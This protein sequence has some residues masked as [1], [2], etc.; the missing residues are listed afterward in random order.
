MMQVQSPFLWG[1]KG[2][3]LTPEQV[4]R[5]REQA[6][7][8]MKGVGD[9]SPVGHWLQGAGRV[10]NAITGKVKERRADASEA[11]GMAG[12][13]EYVRNNPVLSGLMGG[14]Q[15]QPA[16]FNGTM[17]A[18]GSGGLPASLVSSESGGNWGALNSEGYGG[19][20]QFGA[21]RL[22][23][24]ARAGIIPAGMTGAEYSKAP[25]EVQLAVENWHKNNILGDLGKYVGM[26]IDGAG[27][28]PPMTEDSILAVAHLGGTGGARQ[29]IESGGAYNPSDSNGTSL[30]D[31]A[32]SHSGGGGMSASG[33][34]MPIT[35]GGADVV[36]ALASAMS[37]PWVAK[38]Y[39]PVIEALMG[40]QMQ[41]GD[42]QY[43][44]QLAQS[45][46]AYQL[47]LQKS[48]LELDAMRNPAAPKP[49]EV[50]GVLL[51]PTTYQPIFDSRTPDAPEPFTLAPGQ[52][53]FDGAGNPI[54]SVAQPAEPGFT[55]VTPEEATA[56][57][58]PPGAYQKGPDGKIYAIGGGG[59]TVNNDMSGGKFE[60]AFAKGDAATLGLISESGIAATRNLS[61]IDQ[62]ESLLG[63][64]PTG[65]SGAMKQAAG[66][67]GINT[68]GLNEIQAAQALVNS[69]V[70]EQRQP[71]SGP[72]SDAD[73][74]LFKQS[75]PRII[76]QP[77]GNKIIL[78]TMRAIAQ[79]DAQGAAIVQQLRAGDL[80][81]AQAFSMLMARPNPMQGFKP[82][83]QDGGAAE[84]PTS[85]ATQPDADGWQIINGVKMRVKQ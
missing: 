35:G 72:M 6:D 44:Q 4:A 38:K 17:P 8:M 30:A 50:G 47:G 55:E 37:D 58:Y 46:P 45:D 77:G 26:D 13:D 1:S 66:E 60:E 27:P 53:R 43:Q 54:A 36:G 81:R 49:I 65:L 25:P 67:W 10:V 9:T 82:P 15:A 64:S 16:P 33:Q 7:L 83:V 69:L 85:G 18:D 52:Q 48:Q 70:P 40:Q 78:D 42:M 63:S 11:L 71:G 51:D 74:A 20:G 31:Y 29:F 59:V 2:E 39:G 21:E 3:K 80:D 23:D 68:D 12:A 41:R 61:R 19:R 34:P 76:N 73:L 75:L 5:R 24:A 57:G 28:I 32:M 14:G 79:Y 22:A 56:R 62:L 84:T